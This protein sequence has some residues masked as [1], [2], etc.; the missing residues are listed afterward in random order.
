MTEAFSINPPQSVLNSVE[1]RKARVALMR[2]KLLGIRV[3]RLRRAVFGFILTCG[4]N[5]LPATRDHN[6]NILPLLFETAT[7]P[8]QL[9]LSHGVG[10]S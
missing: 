3:C 8:F 10:T 4:T 7:V 1:M 6:T 5:S 2:E 9:C